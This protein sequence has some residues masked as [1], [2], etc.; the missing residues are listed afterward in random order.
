MA[1]KGYINIQFPFQDDPDGKFLKMN[2]DVKQAIFEQNDDISYQ[3]ITNEIND[4][5]RKY[6]PNLTINAI[7]PTKSEDSIYAVI[8]EI[9]YT[10]TTG[11]FQSNDSVTLKL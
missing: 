1:Q 7:T 5:V 3:A 2:D 9:E 10:V 6:I 4:A 11:A 8:V